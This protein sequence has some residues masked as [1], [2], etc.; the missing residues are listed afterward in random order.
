M[1]RVEVRFD[2]EIDARGYDR[3]RSAIEVRLRDGSV[4]TAA[5]DTYPGG[6]E[7]P[8]SPEELRGKFRECA[9]QVLPAERAEAALARIG[10]VER[11]PSLAP[12][13]GELDPVPGGA[14]R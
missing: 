5:A 4:L 6:P 9:G 10:E 7:R 3:M 11:L 8:A 12:L 2:P 13:L 1:R 14:A